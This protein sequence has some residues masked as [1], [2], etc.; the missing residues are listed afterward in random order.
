MQTFYVSFGVQYGSG[1]GK[2]EHPTLPG[3][4]GDHYLRVVAEDEEQARALV[5][6]V[7]GREWAFLYDEHEF[8]RMHNPN[9]YSRDYFPAGEFASIE[10]RLASRNRGE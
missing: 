7:V 8:L 2:M 1:L 3:V 10:F 6:A 5:F 4:S 9:G